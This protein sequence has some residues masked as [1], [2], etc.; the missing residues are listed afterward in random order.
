MP[1]TCRLIV[2]P[3][4]DDDGNV[5]TRQLEVGDMWYLNIA[6]EA[7]KRYHLTDQYF[8]VNAHRQ[9]I[10]IL[11]PG[12]LFFLIDGK[13]FNGERGYYDGWIV[14]GDPPMLTVAPSINIVGHYHGF[15]QSG[16]LS[17]DVEGRKF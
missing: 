2:D 10:A 16:V 1:W 11:L 8:A 15:L 14:T 13:C 12:K 3:P 5:D 6:S 4:R 7:L 17:D 9:P